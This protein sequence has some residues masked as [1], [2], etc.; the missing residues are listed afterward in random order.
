MADRR[1]SGA[2]RK[3]QAKVLAPAKTVVASKEQE[4]EDF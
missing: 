2:G 4:W 1:A 3:T